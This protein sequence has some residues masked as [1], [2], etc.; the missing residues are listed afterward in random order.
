[1]Y[2]GLFTTHYTFDPN[3]N[4]NDIY[5]FDPSDPDESLLDLSG[6][7]NEE[8]RIQDFINSGK[9][10]TDYREGYYDSDESEDQ[11]N[12]EPRTLRKHNFDL[13]DITIAQNNLEHS[14]KS[15]ELLNANKTIQRNDWTQG[16]IAGAK[17]KETKTKTSPQNSTETTNRV[18]EEENV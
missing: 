12:I 15:K 8:D 4:E 13:S 9:V 2:T 3:D 10:L 18:P 7:I 14:I 17:Q 11:E 6:Y 5:H 16:E 1:M